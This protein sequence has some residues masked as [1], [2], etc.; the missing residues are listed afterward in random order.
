[1]TKRYALVHLVA[2]ESTKDLI[3][4]QVL[5][6]A[7]SQA[8]DRS[9]GAPSVVAVAFLEP[10][11]HSLS[12]V[13]RQR[14]R[15]PR[16]RTPDVRSILLPYV[17]RF[18]RPRNARLLAWRLRQITRGL[19][20][21]LHCRGESAV[22]WAVALAPY[23]RKCGIVA[24]IR[25][26]WPEE[27]LFARGFE[28][29]EDA[30]TE[31]RRAHDSAENRLRELLGAAEAVFSVSPAMLDWL[32]SLG[33]P[34]QKL[35]YVP[36]CV[37]NVTFDVVTRQR[38]RD[39]LGV[40]DRIVLCYMGTITRYQHVEDGVLPFFRAAAS[41]ASDVHLLCLTPQAEEMRAL[42]DSSGIP[43]DRVT[44]RSAFQREVAAYLSAADA[45]LLLRAPSRLN[46]F[47][48]PTKLGEYL[49]AGVPVIVSRGT[50]RVDALIAR[51]RA[52]R[53][54]TVFGLTKTELNDE[55]RA[56]C[57]ELRACGSVWRENAL[58]LCRKEFLWTSYTQ[59]VR[60]AYQTTMS[61]PMTEL[62]ME[63][64]R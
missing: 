2:Q 38:V 3:G 50:G 53:V 5:D 21:I 44:I 15:G 62:S 56:T 18:Y 39:Q 4:P 40:T 45:G 1:V 14:L 20:T 37:S 12:R 36:C 8:R 43:A 35:T 11:R 19:P 27:L 22:E 31:S 6:H 10:V 16:A 32:G 33:T 60:K 7:A 29:L 59:I 25:G 49:A 57:N 64:P 24:D 28:S 48:Q 9:E 61:T 55:A 41:Q 52:G 63:R 42:V 46:S 23:L 51:E 13:V 34:R 58:S 30:D 47:S 54:V 26:A 17:S